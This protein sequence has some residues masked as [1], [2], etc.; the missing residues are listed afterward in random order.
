[1][2]IA[3]HCDKSQV[4]AW[5]AKLVRA[6]TSD[7]KHNQLQIWESAYICKSAKPD[8]TLEYRWSILKGSHICLLL[9]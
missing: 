2:G 1:M 5:G 8:L 9:G 7:H 4:L 3:G 6:N